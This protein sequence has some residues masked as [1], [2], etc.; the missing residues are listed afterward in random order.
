ML[1]PLQEYLHR[2]SDL[3]FPL[4]YQ[5]ETQIV[6]V[7]DEVDGCIV[8][9]KKRHAQPGTEFSMPF[10]KVLPG[11]QGNVPGKRVH[12]FVKACSKL[13][14]KSQDEVIRQAGIRFKMHDAFHFLQ[15]N[16]VR[17]A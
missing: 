2:L 17:Y 13:V 4:S 7:P 9:V 15:P 12:V 14:P 8:P 5:S 16:V 10:I 11:N 3:A 6:F 1:Q